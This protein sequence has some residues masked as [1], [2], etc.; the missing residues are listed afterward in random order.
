MGGA[1]VQ[2]APIG[3]PSTAAAMT[4]AARETAP[5]GA[6][7]LATAGD[8]MIDGATLVSQF[9]EV[10]AVFDRQTTA[11]GRSLA[12]GRDLGA[13]VAA[14]RDAAGQCADSA[15]Q[16]F[17]F[18]DEGRRQAGE[19]AAAA[20]GVADAITLLAGQF[21][22]VSAA[23]AEIRGIV[24]M[25]SDIARQTNLLALNAAIEAARA[26]DAGRGFAVVA[27][28]VRVL[29]QRTRTATDD[30]GAVIA[31]IVDNT[32]AVDEA[33]ASAGAA[34]GRSVGLSKGAVRA[35]DG[36][37]ARGNDAL[38]AARS[39]AAGA[40]TQTGLAA[41]IGDELAGLGAVARDGDTAVQRC[42]GT[43]RGVIGRVAVIK[44]GVDDL[45]GEKSPLAV[46]AEAIE[47]M[48]VNNVLIMS[49]RTSA[50]A[51]PSLDRIAVIDGI[52]DRHWRRYAE[53]GPSLPK[54]E[55]FLAALR[56]YRATRDAALA[57]A[58]HGDFAQVRAL[59]TGTVKPS[60]AAAKAAVAALLADG[61][62]EPA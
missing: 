12:L 62:K 26:G 61:S 16:A 56:H 7:A 29:A 9:T 28:E 23:S 52:I 36:V 58:R 34:A 41:S 47:E 49:A 39:M 42:S 27:N 40:E 59:V 55:A 53:S 14:A 32:M 48:R 33:L 11:I 15:A 1:H 37:T 6:A 24:R 38:A 44:H 19:A 60:Y 2:P 31:R 5:D 25:I 30:I 4:D 10:V 54:A 8:L 18:A 21:A 51:Q 43:L 45:R 22:A 20:G 35:L 46:I 13:S 17:A 3:P 57:P 50:E